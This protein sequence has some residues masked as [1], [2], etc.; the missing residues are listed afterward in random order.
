MYRNTWDEFSLGI[1]FRIFCIKPLFIFDKDH[2]SGSH[3][4]GEQKC[5]QVI[6]IHGDSLSTGRRTSERL[7]ALPGT[8]L[9]RQ[10]LATRRNAAR[11]LS[12]GIEDFPQPVALLR[13]LLLG[14][15]SELRGEMRD[16]FAAVGTLHIF[17]ISGLHVGIFCSLIIFVL[18]VLA[19]PRTHWVLFLAP[20]LIAYT[21]ATGGR[22]SAVRACVMAIIYFAAPLCWRKADALSA[23]AL[24]ALLIVLVKPDQIYSLGFVYSFT[25]ALGLILLYPVMDALLNA[26]IRGT[27]SLW[28]GREGGPEAPPLFWE[29]DNMYVGP[30]PKHRPR[31]RA[32]VHA[33]A[34][35]VTLSWAAWLTSVPLTAYFFG[36]FSPIAL[37]GNVLVIPLAFLVVVTGCLSLV[38]GSFFLV[39]A[40]LFNHTNLALMSL[41]V[42]LMQWLGKVPGGSPQ[43]PKFALWPLVAWYLVLGAGA[44]WFYWRRDRE[45]IASSQQGETRDQGR[46]L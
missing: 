31:V 46:R 14:Y 44:A 22:S 16:L 10:C 23:L 32:V 24:A 20:I 39:A 2:R 9:A 21:F 37:V 7:S 3:D 34:S 15:R 38:A 11:L 12:I 33:V 30:E 25:V 41:L 28:P 35:L 4:V 29:Q 36:R 1:F 8:G 13:A 19:I 43:I 42:Q 45:S 26:L 6:P 5:A 27:A 40:E 18:S 17:A